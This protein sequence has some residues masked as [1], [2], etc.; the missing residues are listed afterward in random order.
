MRPPDQHPYENDG[1]DHSGSRFDLFF[2]ER[3]GERFYLRLTPLAAALILGLTLLSIAGIVFLLFY[4]SGRA[5]PMTDVNVRG[6]DPPAATAP[7]NTIIIPARPTPRPPRVVTSTPRAKRGEG[8]S[9]SPHPN[10]DFK[11]TPVKPPPR[12]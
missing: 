4:N 6:A 2:Y 3:V 5:R 1:H 8:V 12:P 11:A 10:T 7:Q 9:P